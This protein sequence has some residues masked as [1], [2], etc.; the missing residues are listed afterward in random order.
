MISACKFPTVC[1]FIPADIV[2]RIDVSAYLVEPYN[3]TP[4]LTSATTAFPVVAKRSVYEH[5]ETQ[6]EQ[7]ET[8]VKCLASQYSA[9][10]ANP[11]WAHVQAAN[12]HLAPLTQ[13]F[14]IPNPYAGVFTNV[15]SIDRQ[16]GCI[17]KD[18]EDKVLFEL[19]DFALGLRLVNLSRV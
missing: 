9:F 5:L 15:G 12:M 2:L 19:N 13:L 8:I 7:L 3:Q 6:K 1:T 18:T 17:W 4:Y 11:H 16:L 14:E 10:R